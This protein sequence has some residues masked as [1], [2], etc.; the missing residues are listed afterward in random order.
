LF[1]PDPYYQQGGDMV[2]V[3][4]MGYTCEP[5]ARR[6]QRIQ[7]L[8]IQGAL[9]DPSKVYKVAGWASVNE[10]QETQGQRPVWSLVEKHL[11]GKSLHQGLVKTPKVQ[12]PKL[13]GVQSNQGWAT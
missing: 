13:R 10:A 12:L 3:G 4:G 6:G 7:N 1:N 11:L 2:R 5:N 8:R 9:M